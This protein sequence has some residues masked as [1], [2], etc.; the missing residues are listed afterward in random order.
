MINSKVMYV[1]VRISAWVE[2]LTRECVITV[3]IYDR[4]GCRLNLLGGPKSLDR[5]MHSLDRV[6]HILLAHP[7]FH[8]E[9]VIYY[10]LKLRRIFNYRYQTLG[11]PLLLCI[12]LR[13][14]FRLCP[15]PRLLWM[16][17]IAASSA[18]NCCCGDWRRQHFGDVA[19]VL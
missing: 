4:F 10:L 13:L 19:L 11:Q 3:V 1:D 5:K 16:I 17:I 7:Y 9:M 15:P 6:Q 2:G 12:S 8:A 14:A 18:A